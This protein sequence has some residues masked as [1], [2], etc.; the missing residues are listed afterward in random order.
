MK[1]FT[2]ALN[3]DWSIVVNGHSAKRVRDT[4]GVNLLSLN[5]DEVNRLIADPITLVDVIFVLCKDE[6][7]KRK[8]TDEQFAQG[9]VGD[10][11]GKA[12]RAMLEEV[13][14]FFQ[15]G[16]RQAL[17]KMLDKNEE[18][19]QVALGLATSEI[20][21]INVSAAAKELLAMLG[22]SSTS[23]QASPA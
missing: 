5:L 12:T 18:L 3:R 16:Q 1:T 7:E 20:D 4:L 10:P 11:L 6:V 15:S 14:N 23:S 13:A 22:K 19:Q 9:L 2:D 21:R 8:L 17:L